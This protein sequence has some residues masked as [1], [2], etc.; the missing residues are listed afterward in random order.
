MEGKEGGMEGDEGRQELPPLVGSATPFLRGSH[1]GQ[2]LAEPSPSPRLP[3][4]SGG[5]RP[6]H[7]EPQLGLAEALGTLPPPSVGA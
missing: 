6:S 4:S 7:P 1:P 3:A 2:V 5:D